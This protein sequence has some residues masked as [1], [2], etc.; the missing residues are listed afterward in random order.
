M[1]VY[2][3]QLQTTIKYELETLAREL[4]GTI[5]NPINYRGLKPPNLGVT[6]N[7]RTT[8]AVWRIPTYY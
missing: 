2:C 6:W 3:G 4:N 1:F 7:L 8:V 5:F